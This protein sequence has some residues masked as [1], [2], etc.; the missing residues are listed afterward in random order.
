MGELTSI[1]RCKS[2][3]SAGAAAFHRVL[4]IEFGVLGRAQL[5]CNRATAFGQGC[6]FRIVALWPRR[7]PNR[8]RLIF[9]TH[10]IGPLVATISHTLSSGRSC[11]SLASLRRAPK[12]YS[13]FVCIGDLLPRPG[14]AA[15]ALTSLSLWYRLTRYR[16][17]C[18]QGQAASLPAHAHDSW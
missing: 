6:N 10:P 2:G 3:Q 15:A 5:T 17:M 14:S 9:D 4:L 18:H 1:I 16:S 7:E 13:V 11:P 12:R 8:A